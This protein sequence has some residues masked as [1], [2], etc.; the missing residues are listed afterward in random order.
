MPMI[1]SKVTC[2]VSPEQR[3]AVKTRLGQAVA[4]LGKAEQW[5]MVGFEDNYD[6]YF[7]GRRQEKAAFVSVALYGEAAPAACDR[8]T[9]EICRIWQEELGIPGDRIYVTYRFVD[10]WGWNGA[11]F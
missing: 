5:L 8:M 6:L 7:A 2:A 4:A 11:N 10:N 3:E 1:D 9:T